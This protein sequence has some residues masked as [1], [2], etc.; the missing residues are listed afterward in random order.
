[1]ELMKWFQVSIKLNILECKY[2]N[3]FYTWWICKCINLSILE[4]K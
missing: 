1:M 3:E 4:C 2:K